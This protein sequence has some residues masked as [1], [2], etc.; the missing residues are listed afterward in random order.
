[1]PSSFMAFF[2]HD[3][4]ESGPLQ[5]FHLFA[6]DE[7]GCYERQEVIDT[8]VRTH[9]QYGDTLVASILILEDQA[10]FYPNGTEW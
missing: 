8:F 9:K 4:D 2:I 5:V 1:M 6:I 10:F 7:D 3:E